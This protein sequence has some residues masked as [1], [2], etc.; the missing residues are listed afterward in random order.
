VLGGRGLGA[1]RSSLGCSAVESWV[2]GSRV[3]GARQSDLRCSAVG[4][5]VLGGRGPLET[6]RAMGDQG[7]REAC[8]PVGRWVLGGPATA[9]DLSRVESSAVGRSRRTYRGMGN[10]WW[11]TAG[12]GSCVG[13]S[14][15][16]GPLAPHQAFGDP[17]SANAR[18]RLLQR[19]SALGGRLGTD[20]TW[21]GS[22]SLDRSD[23]N[24]GSVTT[25]R[26]CRTSRA[27]TCT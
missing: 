17:R 16:R 23:A 27:K 18:Y 4:S 20:H 24:K 25:H 6:D 7:S 11:P 12:S 2:L 15:V 5:W 13:S 1:R 10:P 14:A 19:G 9:R 8:L 3:L 21:G 22:W 26:R